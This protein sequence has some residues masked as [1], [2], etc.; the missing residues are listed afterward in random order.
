MP[1]LIAFWGLLMRWQLQLGTTSS[2]VLTAV[3][4][5]LT[6]LVIY[7]AQ[8]QRLWC[9]INLFEPDRIERNFRSA[10]AEPGSGFPFRIAAGSPRAALFRE[11]RDQQP[12]PE[13]FTI[14]DRRLNTTSW[15]EE[16]GMTGLV[17]LQVPV[18]PF[19]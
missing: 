10:T 2:L 5:V 15:I 13:S 3:V 16:H 7:R 18:S 19:R 8:L 4:V 11:A 6:T 17:V 12:L 14:E 1:E 9:V